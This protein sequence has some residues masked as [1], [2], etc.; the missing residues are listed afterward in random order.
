MTEGVPTNGAPPAAEPG[1]ARP[2]AAS[3]VTAGAAP[4]S[5]A[6]SGPGRTAE[7][8]GGPPRGGPPRSGPPRLAA[9]AKQLAEAR[10]S[11]LARALEAVVDAGRQAPSAQ[12]TQPLAFVVVRDP[13]VRDRTVARAAA[14]RS[15]G[16]LHWPMPML[17]EAPAL[18]AVLYDTRRREPGV[19]GDRT[20]L[21]AV[22]ATLESMR[23]A[24]AGLGHAWTEWRPSEAAETDL[25]SWLGFP[26][27]VQCHAVV[28][29]IP[30]RQSPPP[31]PSLATISAERFGH[32]D[33]HLRQGSVADG[34]GEPLEVLRRRTTARGHFVSATLP[35][36]VVRAL[37]AG[38]G[39]A[40]R[41]PG[42]SAPRLV[43]VQ[44]PTE[45]GRFADVMFDVTAALY[46]DDEY[47]RQIAAWQSTDE[48]EWRRRGDGLLVLGKDA[49]KLLRGPSRSLWSR[50]TGALGGA[51]VEETVRESVSELVREAPLVIAWGISAEERP[52]GRR[53]WASAVIDAGASAMRVLYE[54][55]RRGLAAQQ[56]PSVLEEIP[57]P[58]REGLAA[59]EARVKELLG[60]PTGIEVVNVARVGKVDPQEPA[61]PVVWRGDVRRERSQVVFDERY[62]GA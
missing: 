40:G 1:A 14:D 31:P 13:A 53:P 15:A 44:S 24:T 29:V 25:R 57:G 42:I 9:A 3:G 38:S 26:E 55:E 60:A 16:A 39:I 62:A 43:F 49:A 47:G 56:V 32:L 22:G 50:L 35:P 8:R 45:I 18:I 52:E 61:P 21:L 7:P 54:A 33:A 34:H 2:G 12:N 46:R 51:S 11:T 19:H 59:G 58:R 27:A 17:A 37:A 20:A 28:G 41:A 30:E 4:T 6:P 23:I 5:A 10:A 36:P 48:A